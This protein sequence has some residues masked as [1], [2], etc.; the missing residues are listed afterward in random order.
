MSKSNKQE[1]L[2]ERVFEAA[3]QLVASEGME[4]LNVRKVAQMSSCALGSIYN[5]FGSFS[6]LQFHINAKI[7]SMLYVLLSKT[8]DE[9]I[10]EQKPLR[11][12][13]RDIGHT[14]VRFGQENPLLWKALFEYFHAEPLPEWYVKY[15]RE[16]IAEIC[17][18][19]AIAYHLSQE[20]AKRLYGYFWASVHGL[21]SIL[22]NRKMEVVAELFSLDS[23][24]S[25][26]D[27][28]LDGL[29]Q[30]EKK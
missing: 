6:D 2:R 16:G 20:D 3:W 13:F 21:S 26:I 15:A 5:V 18:R 30:E 24:D 19:L 11:S 10:R 1:K 9:G 14:Y 22:L 8:I 25:Y 29:L 17:T 4:K 7:L 12:L 27:Y 28:C 23:I